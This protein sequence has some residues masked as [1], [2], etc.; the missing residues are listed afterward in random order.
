MQRRQFHKASA[1]VTFASLLAPLQRTH[2]QAKYPAKP[3]TFIV[4][5]AAGGGGDVVARLLAKGFTDRTGHS[6]IVE[7]R[8]GAGGNLGA[9]HVMKSAADGYTLLNMSSTYPIQAAVSKLPFDPLEDMQ[10]IM[11]VSRDP[12]VV[13]THMDSPLKG[14]RELLAASQAKPEALTYGSAGIGSIAHLGMEELAFL[15]GVKWVHVPYKG[16]SQAFNDVIGRQTDMMLT[17]ATFAAPFIKSGRVRA[18]GIAGRQRLAALPEVATFVEQGV[19]YH[20]VDWKAVAGPRGLAPEVLAYLNRELN[21]VLKSRAVQDKFE[22]EGTFAVGGT[23]EQMMQ[24]VRADIERWR[25]LVQRAKIKV[26]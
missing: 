12:A 9:G 4:P 10:P 23:P 19:D 21:E 18:I 16:S 17:S 22:A 6:V 2:A 5:F 14:V 20:T 26:E 3:I 25:A 7:N 24:T 13:V 11:M 1:S 15:M 8:A